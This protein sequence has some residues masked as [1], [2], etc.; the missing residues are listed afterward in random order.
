MDANISNMENQVAE[1][2]KVTHGKSLI[3]DENGKVVYDS[4]QKLLTT[5]I[6]HTLL[7][8][9]AQGSAGASTTRCPA[10]IG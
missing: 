4:D 3:V 7:Y 5:D 9:K 10:E 6:S 8:R 2:D 1:L